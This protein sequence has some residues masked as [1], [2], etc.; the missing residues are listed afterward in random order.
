MATQ[1]RPAGFWTKDEGFQTIASMVR[2]KISEADA[3]AALLPGHPA[4]GPFETMEA[5]VLADVRWYARAVR[6]A[7]GLPGIREQKSSERAAKELA[8]E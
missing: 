6:K 5:A 2:G 3:V 1:R 8:Q 7:L 4:L